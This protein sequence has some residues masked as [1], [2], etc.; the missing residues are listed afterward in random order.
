MHGQDED[1]EYIANIFQN[2][3][4]HD[5]EA[6]SR[7]DTPSTNDDES[8]GKQVKGSEVQTVIRDI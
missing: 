5:E 6:L 4:A 8:D 2:T 3:L 7:H 1:L